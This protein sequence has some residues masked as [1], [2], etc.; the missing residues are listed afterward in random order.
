MVC[1]ANWMTTVYLII[2]FVSYLPLIYWWVLG[3]SI[4]VRS[5]SWPP[6]WQSTGP[7]PGADFPVFK[8]GM[9]MLKQPFCAAAFVSFGIFQ[10]QLVLT[11]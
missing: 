11:F 4:R 2:L 5:K 10:A 3:N 1:T 8:H 7:K 9:V 6:L